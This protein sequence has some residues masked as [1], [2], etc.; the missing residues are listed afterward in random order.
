[1]FEGRWVYSA[2]ELG[3]PVPCLSAREAYDRWRAWFGELPPEV[4]I[5]LVPIVA[6]YGRL[7]TLYQIHSRYYRILG[8]GA[9]AGGAVG[10][11][12]GGCVLGQ[13]AASPMGVQSSS[14]G[15]FYFI[16]R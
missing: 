10:L 1:M 9:P 6:L 12:G 13:G 5:G 16:V 8:A 11:R 2:P 15:P 4:R 3:Q 7:S 14:H